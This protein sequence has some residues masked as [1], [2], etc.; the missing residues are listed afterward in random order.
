MFFVKCSVHFQID[1]IARSSTNCVVRARLW[2]VQTVSEVYRHVSTV[3][4]VI[5]S[6]SLSQ[7]LG[8]TFRNETFA[9]KIHVPHLNRMTLEN[10]QTL[11]NDR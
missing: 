2:I 5:L 11:R 3:F 1:Y 7:K 6:S 4:M 10:L 8:A 9:T